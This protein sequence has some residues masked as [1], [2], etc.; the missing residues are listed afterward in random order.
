M[1]WVVD[2]KR[3]FAGGFDRVITP[4]NY[5]TP[6]H[7]TPPHNTHRTSR[8]GCPRRRK[9][10]CC[11]SSSPARRSCGASTRHSARG[12]RITAR[13]VC[14]LDFGYVGGCICVSG[15]VG[16]CVRIMKSPSHARTHEHSYTQFPTAGGIDPDGALRGREP[17]RHGPRAG[18]ARSVGRLT[19]TNMQHLMALFGGDFTRINRPSSNG[20]TESDNPSY[21][22]AMASNRG[23]ADP[24]GAVCA[25]GDSAGGGGRRPVRFTPLV[26]GVYDMNLCPP[27]VCSE[28][29]QSPKNPTHRH[30]TPQKQT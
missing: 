17:P 7:P 26:S 3:P 13:C 8:R 25:G 5:P 11:G 10:G 18:H 6:Q 1:A 16:V 27:C 29:P 15:F 14:V 20:L 21:S 19:H 9:S 2:R 22:L 24:A 23:R 4:S 28:R 12:A 30:T